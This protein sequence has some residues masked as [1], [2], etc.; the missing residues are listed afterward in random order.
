MHTFYFLESS[1]EC[2]PLT[3]TC[4]DDP[5]G[6][7]VLCL[8][9]VLLGL[10]FIQTE[11]GTRLLTAGWWGASRHINYFGDWLMGVAWCLPCGTCNTYVLCVRMCKYVCVHV[12]MCSVYVQYVCVHVCMHACMRIQVFMR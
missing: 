1:V 3:P 6:A 7:R 2:A 5:K 11:V 8:L 12:C 9:H 4:V 10:S